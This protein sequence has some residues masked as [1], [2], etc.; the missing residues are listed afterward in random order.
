MRIL[1]NPSD[2]PISWSSA[3]FNVLLALWMMGF[4]GQALAQLKTNALAFDGIDDKVVLS[5]FNN[6]PSGGSARTIEAWI[7]TTASSNT[8]FAYG[9]NHLYKAVNLLVNTGVYF[10]SSDSAVSWTAGT[11]LNDGQWHH[12]AWVYPGGVGLQNSLVYADGVLMTVNSTYHGTTPLS[13][14]TGIQPHLGDLVNGEIDDLRLWNVARTQTEIQA[15]KEVE[16]TG[17]EPGLVAYY[18]FNQCSGTLLPDLT[19]N[20]ND[21]TLTNMTGTEWTGCP[22]PMSATNVTTTGFTATWKAVNGATKYRI[23]VGDAS[24]STLVASNIDAGSGTSFDVTGLSLTPGTP[25][26][27]RMRVEMGAWTSPNS[28]SSV[29]LSPGNVLSLGGAS[30]YVQMND[31]NLGT[32]DFT[33]EGWIKPNVL[34]GYIYSTRT[35]ETGAPGNWFIVH[36]KTFELANCASSY[37]AIS[38][39]F[40]PTVGVWYHFAIVRNPTTITLYFNGVL[41]KQ[42]ADNASL[43]NLTTNNVTRFG[44][45]PSQNVGWYNG[46][47]DEFRVWNVARTQTEIQS[48]LYKTLAGNEAGLVAYYNFD[49]PSGTFLPDVTGHGHNGTL[50]NGPTWTST[51]WNYGYPYILTGV[52]SAITDLSA[53]VGGNVVSDGIPSLSASGI[54][55]GTGASPTTPCTTDGA[56]LGT[57]TSALTGLTPNTLYHVREYATNARATVYGNEVT[58]TTLMGNQVIVFSPPTSATYG[59]APLTLTATGGNS[60]NPVTFTSTTTSVCTTGGTNGAMLTIV[61]AGTCNVTANQAGNSD[62]NPATPVN[63][64]LLISKANQTINFTLP[65]SVTY[66]PNGTVPLSYN[67]TSGLTVTLANLTPDVCTIS[68]T[69]L[70]LPSAGTCTVMA[71]QAGNINYNAAPSVSRTLTINLANQVISFTLPTSATYGNASLTLTAAG[72][73][74]GNPV[75][76]TSTTT[77]VCTTGGTNRATLTIV[78][79]GT[80]TVTAN[81]LGNGN[82]QAAASVSRSLSVNPASQTIFFT[83]LMAAAIGDGPL[84]LTA[85]AT[86]GLPV[87][88]TSLTPGVCMVNGT[89]LFILNAGA[90][91]VTADQQGNANYQAAPPVS[92]ETNISP[93]LQHTL[94][95]T[96]A[97]TGQG[98]VMSDPVG[99]DC[100]ATTSACALTIEGGPRWVY[101]TPTPAT[102]STFVNWSGD[103]ACT[104]NAP[105][106]VFLSQNMACIATFEL[107][108]YTLTV[109]RN[110][111]GVTVTGDGIRCQETEQ[112]FLNLE[113]CNNSSCTPPPDSLETLGCLATYPYGTTVKLTVTPPRKWEFLGWEG[114]C[115]NQG[116]VILTQDRVCR[117]K[118]GSDSNIP[119]AGDGNGD[120]ILDARQENVMSLPDKVAGDYITLVVNPDCVVADGS[121]LLASELD[122]YDPNHP[123]PQGLMYFE[124]GCSQTSVTMYFHGVLRVPRNVELLKYGP[125][126]PGDENTVGWYKLPGAQFSLA[127]VGGKPV[128][129]VTYTLTDGQLGDNTGVDGKIVDPAGLGGMN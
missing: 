125:T 103:P 107:K 76:F 20:N 22:A 1:N 9:T 102:G 111:P 72:G 106:K 95:L 73:G 67:S 92:Q 126:L 35:T 8:L 56:T 60:G 11:P 94:N 124:I 98:S 108:S 33:V 128:A 58:F 62:Y 44:G 41:D 38:G 55:Y 70:T 5:I 129:T 59:D 89:Q 47:I 21:G 19:V 82:Y 51:T 65:T 122:N 80:C 88:F 39:N 81:Q 31:V 110:V 104:E 34:T 27:Y 83:P 69:T 78:N 99:L 66:S 50:V 61:G 96:L 40:T 28:A 100:S 74:S 123:A 54:C 32:A 84:T 14:T 53:S 29:M 37:L 117:A 30:Q 114:S 10:D 97:G 13:T 24:F 119:N 64:S 121:T 116:Q 101:L 127:T 15:N 36:L 12:V 115:D 3:I 17:A 7:K 118:F 91:T 85:S 46:Q 23:D 43:R 93:I 90:C 45:N 63:G 86:S 87:T 42:V 49:R 52:A 105:G 120:G 79:A 68:G 75:T 25:Y 16:L 4:G 112:G 26:Y 77:N 6:A 57:F 18:K 71:N 48:N 113:G 109:E 2:R